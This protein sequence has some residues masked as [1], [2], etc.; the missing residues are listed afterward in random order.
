M[1]IQDDLAAD[2]RSYHN[3][4][5]I[6]RT[7]VR[8]TKSNAW[9]RGQTFSDNRPLWPKALRDGGSEEQDHLSEINAIESDIVAKKAL[10]KVLYASKTNEKKAIR[11]PG[12]VVGTADKYHA[13]ARRANCL[14]Q[15]IADLARK[16]RMIK[17]M[18]IGEQDIFEEYSYQ[19][20]AL[21]SRSS[22]EI[23]VDMQH[24]GAPTRLLDWTDHVNIAVYFATRAIKLRLEEHGLD[25]SRCDLSFL[26]HLS[27]L[28]S[29]CI[30]VIN[31]YALSKLSTGRLSII[32]VARAPELDYHAI[33]LNRRAWPFDLPI[34]IYPPNV[35]RRVESQKSFFTVHGND[36]SPLDAQL[37]KHGAVLRKV[38]FSPAEALCALYNLEVMAGINEF[39][40]F[41]DKDS[42]G[43]VLYRKFKDAQRW[44]KMH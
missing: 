20:G 15:E 26:D 34:P 16:I 3:K 31:P 35:E 6:A 17:S 21:P 7:S 42:L 2:W 38:E 9:Y 36:R 41:R 1:T 10:L 22:W 19:I 43:K 44:K 28:K 8:C 30:W 14:K 27:G 11:L 32:D 13:V 4:L 33:F 37:S 23:L 24:H 5:A 29:P 40:I 25:V 12:P 18:V 39:T